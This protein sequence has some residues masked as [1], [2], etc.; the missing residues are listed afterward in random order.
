METTATNGYDVY[1][2]GSHKIAAIMVAPELTFTKRVFE[3]RLKLLQTSACRLSI[4]FGEEMVYGP[5]VNSITFWYDS[6]VS[7]N[8][9]AW[10][11]S[12]AT[13]S[14]TSTDTGVAADTEWHIFRF[15]QS[16]SD[17]K[18]YIDGSLVATHT[19]NMP[20]LGLDPT[21][22]DRVVVTLRTD[23]DVSKG[24]AYEYVA[25]WAE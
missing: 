3:C 16:S 24:V 20:P 1:S 21:Y 18:F 11:Y 4:G 7:A 8:F 25:V 17:I 19:T 2:Y 10:N 22:I 5:S 13:G 14:S 23:E 15:E 9:L 12:E 6:A